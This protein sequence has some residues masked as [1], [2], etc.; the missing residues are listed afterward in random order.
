M[1]NLNKVKSSTFEDFKKNFNKNIKKSSGYLS[2]LTIAAIGSTSISNIAG[3]ASVNQGTTVVTAINADTDAY[4][5]TAA[6]A[7]TTLANNDI[8]ATY[9]NSDT[10]NTAWTL[11]GGKTL[12]VTGSITALAQ[13]DT[14]AITLAGTD[15]KLALGEAAV[16]TQSSG[17]ITIAAGAGTTVQVT[18][19]DTHVWSVNGSSDGV[20]ALLSSNNSTFSD[21]IGTTNALASITQ[22]T[23]KTGTFSEAVEATTINM[24]GTG[25]FKKAITATSIIL[26]GT[27]T[28]NNTAVIAVAG[29]FTE[30]AAN[31]T[32]KLIIKET[33][34]EAGA[35]ATFANDITLDAI[36]IGA[37]G[38]KAGL[39]TFTGDVS[40]TV[41]VTGGDASE[42][43]A[44][45]FNG[46]QTGA[47]TLTRAAANQGEATVTLGGSAATTLTGAV[48]ASTDSRGDLVVSN[49]VGSTV[50]STIG[51]D[52][53]KLDSATVNANGIATFKAATAANTLTV[54]GTLTLEEN[55]N[56]SEAFAMGSAGVLFINKTV[57]NGEGLIDEVA[58]TRPTIA[59]GAKIY[60]P[61]N[62]ST[63][64]TL[65]MFDEEADNSLADHASTIT[66]AN[67]A[68]QDTA[69]YN[70]VAASSSDSLV[71]TVNAKDSAT[72]SSELGVTKNDSIALMQALAAATNDTVADDDAEEAFNNALN[73][74][75]GLTATDDTALA[76]QVAPQTDLITGSAVAAKAMTGSVQGVISNRM[77]SL[78]SG[79]AYFAGMS[80]GDGVSAN[81]MF[82]QAFG[83]SVD[84]DNTTVGSGI[85]SGYDADTAGVA[86][87][88]DGITDG[89]LIVGLSL[90]MS[91]TDLEG[92]GTGKA[93]N[94]IDSYTASLYMDKTSDKG[95]VEG[96]LTFGLSENTA[97]R[98]INSA[99]LDRTLT[100]A[101]DTQQV[102]IKIGGG[103]PYEA[104]N[105]SYVT[106]FASVTGTLIENDAYKERSNTAGDALRLRVNQNDVNSI[107][108]TLGVKA[109]Y[110]TGNGTPMISLAVNNEFGDTE[111]VSS[112]NFE[113][114]GTAFN[115]STEVEEL[116]ATLGL[117]YAFSNGNT[118][119]SF[120]LE[121]EANDDKYLSTYGTIKLSSRF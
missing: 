60:M 54:N 70:Y 57:T 43:A 7:T 98:I 45:V 107:V 9:V 33:A 102:S 32:T 83:S 110:D 97:S 120:G 21:V 62:L 14:I 74:I 58:T 77:A 104:N 93:K 19:A 106:P 36:E 47:V 10:I 80:A 100:S 28:V 22:I 26:D 89:G 46:N 16:E 109:H 66:E 91:N 17:V 44:A 15:T 101:Y 25:V 35:I 61:E 55:E 11:N 29:T 76:K 108:G 114:G 103:L 20:G 68:I 27:M 112:N 115:T 23:G 72:T 90:S 96:S 105:G 81:S 2:M 75:N 1:T 5:F 12:T 119:V 4:T 13:G 71:V 50:T 8:V 69:L 92:K 121:A 3:A 82:L 40:G 51:T 64:Q 18:G 118:D 116:S 37:A 99:G 53:A 117:G 6:T 38:D 24:V 86:F 88:I 65:I 41:L 63:G 30:S 85:Q 34:D 87:G 67:A 49:T 48:I 52:A 73:T 59:A 84:Q 79:D 111:I 113:G 39:A 78:R 95:Y 42:A 56:G 94:D 31:D